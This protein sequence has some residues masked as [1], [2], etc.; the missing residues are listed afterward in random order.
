MTPVLKTSRR[1]FL[2]ISFG[3][4]FRIKLY[5]YLYIFFYVLSTFC[6]IY[7]QLVHEDGSFSVHSYNEHYL[8]ITEYTG[9]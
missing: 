1:L 2:E 8:S 6:T 5:P 9:S 4:L 3:T 7:I